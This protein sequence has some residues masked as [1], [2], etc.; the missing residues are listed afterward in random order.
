MWPS[1][2]STAD[3]RLWRNHIGNEDVKAVDDR[4]EEREKSFKDRLEAIRNVQPK[5]LPIGYNPNRNQGGSVA[6]G[7]SQHHHV[8]EVEEE[9][10]EEDEIDDAEMG[11]DDDDFASDEMVTV[12]EGQASDR[13]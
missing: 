8:E 2:P 3:A 6:R 12:G 13:Y 9:E 10:E 11:E 5:V 4:L 7:N 1:L